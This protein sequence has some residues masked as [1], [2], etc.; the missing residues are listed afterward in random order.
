MC[1]RIG[2]LKKYFRL[3]VVYIQVDIADMQDIVLSREMVIH[4]VILKRKGEYKGT[5]K[6]EYKVPLNVPLYDWIYGD[7]YC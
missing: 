6:G 7:K 2:K 5:F 4:F 3:K 1:C